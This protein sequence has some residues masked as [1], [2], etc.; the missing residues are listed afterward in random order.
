MD[1][2]I[3]PVKV[4]EL[5]AQFKLARE[6]H[7]EILARLATEEA[8]LQTLA[9]QREA[10]AGRLESRE[11]AIAL[12]GEPLPEDALPEDAEIERLTRH[13]RIVRARVQAIESQEKTAASGVETLKVETQLALDDF[14]LER[15]HSVAA[16]YRE[17]AE[18]LRDIACEGAA[19]IVAT[20]QTPHR[21][22]ISM[23]LGL[24]VAVDGKGETIVD[25]RNLNLSSTPKLTLW[26][27][28]GGDV[29]ES[30]L[31]LNREVQ[32]G[33]Q[34]REPAPK[35]VAANELG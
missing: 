12:S 31:S 11:T 18:K 34:G 7:A 9:N 28:T 35:A 1:E 3:E 10:A 15:Y 13:F 14:C 17:A 19:L 27:R 26:Y 30:I 24:T 29:Y 2:N 6:A 32:A 20:G 33:I 21:R 25:S 8:S 5:L 22:K 23:A 16:R 4:R